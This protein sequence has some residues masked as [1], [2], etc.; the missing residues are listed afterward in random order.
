MCPS[1]RATNGR[2]NVR[3]ATPVFSSQKLAVF[4][5]T[6]GERATIVAECRA[7]NRHRNPAQSQRN[8]TRPVAAPDTSQILIVL[9]NLVVARN[10]PSALKLTAAGFV[11]M[12]VDRRQ[13]APC[14]RIEE[15]DRFTAHDR[16][17]AVVIAE[18]ENDSI[19][20]N[21]AN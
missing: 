21:C 13:I 16:A 18:S 5:S 15:S 2:V 17:L 12:A 20:P 14:R 6:K 9:S 19:A 3:K 4:A 11:I 8:S 1:L 10:F 7:L